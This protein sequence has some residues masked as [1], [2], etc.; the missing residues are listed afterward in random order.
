MKK[1][2]VAA[3]TAALAL[4]CAAP[5]LATPVPNGNHVPEPATIALLGLGLVGLVARARRKK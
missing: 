1:W 3:L 5:A 2:R 4:A